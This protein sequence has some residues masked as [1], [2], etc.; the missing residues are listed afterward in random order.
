LLTGWGRYSVLVKAIRVTPLSNTDPGPTHLPHGV[1]EPSACH[2]FAGLARRR[3]PSP[4][5][6][7]R[8]TL[9]LSSAYKRG[10]WPEISAL[11]TVSSS[12]PRCALPPTRCQLATMLPGHLLIPL[13]DLILALSRSF[14]PRFCDHQARALASIV[15]PAGDLR[16]HRGALTPVLPVIDEV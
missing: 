12:T 7:A 5:P 13:A 6:G 10:Q 15:H 1:G 14:C 2:L 11:F 4:T 3:R 16:R 9:S 8:P